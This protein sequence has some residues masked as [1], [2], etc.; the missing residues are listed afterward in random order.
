[1]LFPELPGS[2][3][4]CI[5][6]TITSRTLMRNWYRQLYDLGSSHRRGTCTRIALP[7]T[8]RRGSQHMQL[9]KLLRYRQI[10]IFCHRSRKV[11]RLERLSM[12]TVLRWRSRHPGN[13]SAT[14]SRKAYGPGQPNYR[15][16]GSPNRLR[17]THRSSGRSSKCMLCYRRAI[18]Q[19]IHLGNGN[20]EA[21]SSWT[22]DQELW[23]YKSL[24]SL[25]LWIESW[26][27]SSDG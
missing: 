25:L 27:E 2:L 3:V 24:T 21:D 4:E 16:T 15:Y 14:C 11:G 7:G 19:S 18:G 22:A 8:W 13:R 10:S 1:M 9:L 5:R 20:A 12:R 17:S 23:N 26:F 6:S